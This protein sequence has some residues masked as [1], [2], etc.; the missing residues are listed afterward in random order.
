[1]TLVTKTNGLS[2]ST[3]NRAQEE[4]FRD[5]AESLVQHIDEVFFWQ[6]PDKIKP[7]FVSN[8]FEKIWGRPCE[9]AYGEPSSWIESIHADDRKRVLR[10]L[11]QAADSGDRQVEYRI[12]RPSGEIRWVWVRTFPFQDDAGHI[13]RLI[14]IAQDY[15]ERKQAEIAQAY[16]ASIVES[17]DDSIVGSDLDG[18]ILSWNVGAEKLFGYK[19]EEVI[20]KPV[21]ILFPPAQPG[22]YLQKTLH[23]AKQL[24]SIKRFETVRVAKGGIPIDVSVILSPIKDSTGQL[25]GLSGVYRDIRDRKQAEKERKL[26][27]LQLQQ[28]QKLESVGRLAAGVAHEINTPVQFVSDSVY[29]VRDGIQ[30]VFDLMEKYRKVCNAVDTATMHEKA[31]QLERAEQD[32]DLPYLLEQMPKALARALDG[33]DRVAVIVRS[34]KEFAHPD[35]TE[36]STVDLNQAIAST[37]T[38][39]RNEYKYVADLETDFGELP[40][41]MCHAGEINQV[42]LN[43]VVNAAHAIAGVVAG[44]EQK[45]RIRVRTWREENAAVIAIE[46]T[47]GGIPPEIQERI[48]DPFFTTKEVGR[49]TGQGLAIARSVIVDKHGGSID[50]ES[51]TG[52]GTKFLI[53]VPIDGNSP[54]T[55]QPEAEDR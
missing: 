11:S 33:L 13:T 25:L 31:A 18:T 54:G 5:F 20:G 37:L 19:S 36:K 47:G 16:L 27:D 23:R 35:R 14:G 46:D 3:H 50:F 17:S 29:F 10:H 24:Q 51:Q 22:E 1:M 43:V 53:R 28:A 8:A 34:M 12:V 6:D 26:L 44:T 21:T 49:G 9:S 45:G 42:V 55:A 2:A 48:F 4:G 7:Y 39:A 30:A 40:P 41:V 32:M 52:C 15:T 38:V